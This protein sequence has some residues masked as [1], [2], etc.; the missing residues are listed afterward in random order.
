MIRLLNKVFP[1]SLYAE[2]VNALLQLR[3]RFSAVDKF[4]H[5]ELASASLFERFRLRPG[6]TALLLSLAFVSCEKEITV[7]LPKTEPKLV[8]EGFIEQGIPPFIKLTK[9]A[10]F[11]EPADS[12]SLADIIVK[13]ATV[14]ISDGAQKYTLFYFQPADS[15][16]NF[17]FYTS[18]GLIGQVGKDYTL[19]IKYK[20]SIYTSVTHIPEPVKLDSL[21]FKT[22]GNDSLGF[23]WATLSDP[24]GVKN[25]YRWFAQRFNKDYLPIPPPFSAFDDKFFDGTTFDFPYDRGSVPNSDAPDDTTSERGYFKKGDTVLI[26]F[27]SIP[28][29]VYEFL[30]A[31]EAET[32]NSG[33]PFAAPTTI[34]SN[35]KGGALGY[36]GGY[37]ASYDTVVCQ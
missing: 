12:A 21:W 28:Q 30:R 8:V 5:A 24:A 1:K 29:D 32:A 37:G 15:I 20:D 3:I 33:N 18:F 26:R 16:L 17:G 23:I 19:E 36:W 34:P 10:G 9:S 22:E 25:A 13:D 31:Y 27:C 6:M 35:I 7:D 4:R 2:L 11:F 14:T